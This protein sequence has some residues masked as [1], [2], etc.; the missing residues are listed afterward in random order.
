MEGFLKLEYESCLGL[1]RYY[2]ERQLALVKF[3]TG[4]SSS[5]ISLIFAFRAFGPD[6]QAHFWS[7]AAVLTGVTALGL[8][9]IFVAMIQ[10]R[11]Y[12]VYPARQVNAIRRTMLAKVVAEFA[13]N[14][15]YTSSDIRAFKFLSLHSL[16]NFLVALQVG[17]LIGFC[18]FAAMIDSSDTRDSTLLALLISAAVSISLFALSAWY[19]V[20]QGHQHADRSI[21]RIKESAV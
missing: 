15:M 20:R 11:L 14:Q 2:D 5:V 6:A 9:A 13:D 16:M 21:H 4:I 7:F 12:F 3:T 18:W 17:A 10:N 19:L 1:I 8:L